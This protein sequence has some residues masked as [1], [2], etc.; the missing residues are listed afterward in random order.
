MRCNTGQIVTKGL[1]TFNAA[2]GSKF[3]KFSGSQSC[4]F[5]RKDF[6][7]TTAFSTSLTISSINRSKQTIISC[8]FVSSCFQQQFDPVTS[9][10]SWC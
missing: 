7:E 10:L 3:A 2:H 6:E 1:H 4:R 8:I 9:L 5:T